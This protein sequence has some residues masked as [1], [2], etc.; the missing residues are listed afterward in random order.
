MY[1]LFPAFGMRINAIYEL[2]V[3]NL[4]LPFAV[5]HE[6]KILIIIV[7]GWA[8]NSTDSITITVY[9]HYK[10][11]THICLQMHFRLLEIFSVR[12]SK[13]AGLTRKQTTTELGLGWVH[14]CV[15]VGLGHNIW[16]VGFTDQKILKRDLNSR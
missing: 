1:I 4:T 13:T 12:M 10:T 11:A 14:P 8:L 6:L 15:R 16:R 9:Y 3:K 2:T 5:A 7:S